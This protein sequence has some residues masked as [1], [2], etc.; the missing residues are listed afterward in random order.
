VEDHPTAEDFE[1]FL[2]AS[3]RPSNAQCNS[4]VVRHLLKECGVCR[5]TLDELRGGRALLSRLLEVPLPQTEPGDSGPSRVYNYDWAFARTER[6]VAASLA[7]GG[8]ARGLPERLAELYRLPEGE[9]LRRVS[10]GGRFSDPD[11][12]EVLIERSH[13]A[14]YQSPKKMLHLSRLAL[15]AGEACTIQASGGPEQLADLQ[16]QAWGAY[17]NAQRVCGNVSEAEEALATAFKRYEA[18]SNSPRLKGLLLGQ[19]SSL[20]T[21]QSRFAEAVQLAEEAE[22]ISRKLGETQ[23]LARMMVQRANV[24]TYAGQTEHAA[25][26][27]R[28]AIPKIDQEE[29]PQLFLA[30]RHNL[31]RCYIDLDQPE[32]ALAFFFESKPLYRQC[33]DPLILLRAAWQEGQLLREIGHLESAESVLLRTR[34]SFTQQGLVYE[35]AMISLDLADVYAKGGRREDVRRT[36]LQAMPLF[37]SLR[38]DREVLASLLRL[39]E[40]AGLEPAGEQ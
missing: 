28:Q 6:A 11:L 20:R 35:T 17:G 8:P 39:Q 40:A 38:V 1:R 7:H 22:N 27:L 10:L 9:Q 13:A 2:Q 19:T 30:A 32:E 4:L 16:A 25:E 33:K 24:L 3:P 36:I 21:L 23:V 18:G 37:R 34:E 29:D 14:R 26:I 15:L 31:T 5:E 12:V